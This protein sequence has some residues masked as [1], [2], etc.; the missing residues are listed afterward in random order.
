MRR[1]VSNPYP[2]M[3]VGVLVVVGA[4]SGARAPSAAPTT[5]SMPSSAET[6]AAID[7]SVTDN[8]ATDTSAE[9]ATATVVESVD[10]TVTSTSPTS[11]LVDGLAPDAAAGWR[12]VND[13]VMGGV[14]SSSVADSAD[15]VVFTGTVSLDNNG[16]FASIRN[17]FTDVVDLSGF[18]DLVVD[19]AGDGKTYVVELRT[20]QED[21][22][23]WQ[24]FTP[25]AG[26]TSFALPLDGFA[27][28]T[29]F[30]EP[31]EGGPVPDL[32]RVRSVAIYILDKQVGEFRIIIRRITAR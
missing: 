27:P 16:G 28:H 25:T 31:I 21:V 5:T 23:Y 19:V 12:I 17:V 29:R 3:L 20:D 30:G 15:G 32:T 6:R 8:A 9:A 7:T 11:L 4:C 2:S 18:D 26:A 22:A 13:G 10:G 1:S 24:R 14:S